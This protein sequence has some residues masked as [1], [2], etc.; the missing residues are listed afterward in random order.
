M[1]IYKAPV[2]PA[3]RVAAVCAGSHQTRAASGWEK[4]AT[5]SVIYLSIDLYVGIYAGQCK[6]I[7]STCEARCMWLL[8]L[9]QNRNIRRNDI[10]FESYSNDIS[11]FYLSHDLIYLSLCM[12]ASV[13]VCIRHL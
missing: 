8:L 9:M 7:E 12:P 10:P 13:C 4:I 2:E 1:Y 3:A 5:T 6:Y 11:I